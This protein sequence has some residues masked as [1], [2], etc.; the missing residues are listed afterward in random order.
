M[1]LAARIPIST[2]RLNDLLE[3]HQAAVDAGGPF[4]FI[5]PFSTR[6]QES[7]SGGGGQLTPPPKIWALRSVQ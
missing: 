5:F 7:R 2:A 6:A 4:Q 1:F 3:H